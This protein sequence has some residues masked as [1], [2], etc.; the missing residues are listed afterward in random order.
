MS[1]GWHRLEPRYRQAGPH[2]G[3]DCAEL[4]VA[5][6]DHDRHG[7][8]KLAEPAAEPGLSPGAE[9]AQARR[10]APRRASEPLAAKLGASRVGQQ[11][12]RGKERHPLPGTDEGGETFTLEL[13]SESLV[14]TPPAGAL[15]GACEA[16]RGALEEQA[17]HALRVCERHAERKPSAHRVAHE[18]EATDCD[19]LER[20]D[21]E[22]RGL[23]ERVGVPVVPG[24]R[25]AVSRKVDCHHAVS[26]PQLAAERPPAVLAAGESVEKDDG[27]GAVRSFV[28]QL[29]RAAVDPEPPNHAAS[30]RCRRRRPSAAAIVRSRSVRFRARSLASSTTRSPASPTARSIAAANPGQDATR[31]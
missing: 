8:R 17:L 14:G 1:S 5:T 10:E 21:D 25:T 27:G 11:P 4:F 26:P 18:R 16:R 19:R 29:D 22:F 31:T 30:S 9:R 2:P 15:S 23:P 6:A 24:W 12:Q 28:S 20:P 3:G 7:E 13:A